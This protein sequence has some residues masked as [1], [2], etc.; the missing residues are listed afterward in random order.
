ML[1]DFQAKEKACTCCRYIEASGIGRSDLL[2]NEAGRGWEKHIGSCRCH[3]NE[4]DFL[5]RNLGLLHCLERGL[6][7]H[8]AGVF[9]LCG[10]A[11]LL[12]AGACSD[13]IVAGI[14]H[15]REVLIGQNLFGHIT[16]CADD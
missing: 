14:D 13:P 9:I 8:I 5:R 12:D 16:A 3:D 15:A 6:G 4:I 1:C 7:C 10:D 11:A 2:L